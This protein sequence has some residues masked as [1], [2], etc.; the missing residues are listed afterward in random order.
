MKM[1]FLQDKILFWIKEKGQ[2]PVKGQLFRAADR[3]VS[4]ATEK[5]TWQPSKPG[6]G[7]SKMPETENR[8]HGGTV[9]GPTTEAPGLPGRAL[10]RAPIRSCHL[11]LSRK[12][13]ALGQ[14]DGLSSPAEGGRG[15]LPW[16]SCSAAPG[17]AGVPPPKPGRRTCHRGHRCRVPGPASCRC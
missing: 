2:A 11:Q 6:D 9:L 17:L 15:G 5:V 14:T 10:G 12:S 16:G 13:E 4:V 3:R 7:S 1:V 8:G